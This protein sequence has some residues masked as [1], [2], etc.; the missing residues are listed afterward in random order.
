MAQNNLGRNM[1]FWRTEPSFPSEAQ[2]LLG[3][4]CGHYRRWA[5][6][7]RPG[8]MG[9]LP[10]PSPRKKHSRK[11]LKVYEITRKALVKEKNT[12]R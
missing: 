3:Q 4:G 12:G 6:Q 10:E 1:I 2:T 7:G 9:L 11:S 8:Y 5:A